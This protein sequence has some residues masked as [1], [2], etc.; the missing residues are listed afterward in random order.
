LSRHGKE[1]K[2]KGG[3]RKSSRPD[4]K[5]SRRDAMRGGKNNHP[6]TTERLKTPAQW[7]STS[8][9]LVDQFSA[10]GRKEGSGKHVPTQQTPGAGFASP[11]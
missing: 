4:E 6:V 11:E 10:R 8:R 3:E 1:R 2:K 7:I 5:T 9:A